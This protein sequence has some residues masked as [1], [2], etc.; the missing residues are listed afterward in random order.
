MK[1]YLSFDA[2]IEFVAKH[3]ENRQVGVVYRGRRMVIQ[4]GTDRTTETLDLPLAS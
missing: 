2:M 4:M 3:A 1:N